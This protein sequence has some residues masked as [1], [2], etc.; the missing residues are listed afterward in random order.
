MG[1]SPY[2]Q[3]LAQTH[4]VTIRHWLQPHALKLNGAGE[5]AGIELEATANRDGHLTG[6]GETITLAADMVFKAIGQKFNADPLE[7]S[8]VEME[9]GRIKVNKQRQTSLANVWAGGDCV[10]D[11]EDLTVVAVED[12]KVAAMSIHRTLS[13]KGGDK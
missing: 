5:I 2:E 3:E 7:G 9:R 4:G 11:G 12:G 8:G 13:L 6:T 10:A 1:A